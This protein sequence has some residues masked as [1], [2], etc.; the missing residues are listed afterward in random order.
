MAAEAM[1]SGA[2]RRRDPLARKSRDG[3]VV[4]CTVCSSEVSPTSTSVKPGWRRRV[5]PR[6]RLPRRRSA[7]ISKVRRFAYECERQVGA[8]KGLSIS[9]P[10]AR[11]RQRDWP[12]RAMHVQYVKPDSAERLDHRV[13]ALRTYL[14]AVTRTAGHDAE[15]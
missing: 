15:D 12:G 6:C 10:G 8:H 2:S 13:R 9:T 3:W 1:S 11:Y 5:S 14:V 7:S 4:V